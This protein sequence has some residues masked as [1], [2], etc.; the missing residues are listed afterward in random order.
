MNLQSRARESLLADDSPEKCGATATPFQLISN[1]QLRR[2]SATIAPDS[3]N[4][5]A[6]LFEIG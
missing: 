3:A 1:F 2:Y 6:A 4:G 5:N